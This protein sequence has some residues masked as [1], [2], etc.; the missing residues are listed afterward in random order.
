MVDG[1]TQCVLSPSSVVDVLAGADVPRS[2]EIGIPAL[3][4]VA[5]SFATF[6]SNWWSRASV[7]SKV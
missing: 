2:I 4:N 3:V 1:V 7:F 5:R 6:A